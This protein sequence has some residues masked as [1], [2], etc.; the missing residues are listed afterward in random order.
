M[1]HTIN[2]IEMVAYILIL[3]SA[4]FKGI[5]L[6]HLNNKTL[7]FQLRQKKYIKYNIICYGF[8]LPGVALF[9]YHFMT[10]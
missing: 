8:L 10:K 1:F 7:D 5:A 9:A 4:V 6:M 3:I 2:K